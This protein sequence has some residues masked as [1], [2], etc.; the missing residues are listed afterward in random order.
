MVDSACSHPL[1]E[2]CCKRRKRIAGLMSGTSLDGLDV[3][4]LDIEGNGLLTCWKLLAFDIYKYPD[5]IKTK[6]H[7][8]C[9]SSIWNADDLCR[10]NVWL[11]KFFANAVIDLCKQSGIS[12][13]QI[14]VIGS[15]GQTIRHLPKEVNFS[16]LPIAG[17][18][19]VG[20]P[21][22]IAKLTG[23]P[24]V[25]DFRPADMALGGQGAP[26]VPIVDYML[27]RSDKFNRGILNIGGISNITIIDA[28]A[29]QA[30]VFAFDIGPGNMIIDRL[31]QM[32]FDKPMDEEARIASSGSIHHEFLL[33]LLQFDYL[34]IPP[35]KSTGR[36][37]F[38]DEFI[39][40]VLSQ[41]RQLNLGDRDILATVT[42]FVS[43]CVRDALQKFVAPGLALDEI[44]V[45]GGGAYNPLIMSHLAASLRPVK[46]FRSDDAGIP[47]DAK[48][49][50]CFAILANETLAGHPGN[51]PGVTGAQK[52]TILGKICL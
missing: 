4:I 16:A 31:A 25:A 46:V 12:P 49:A 9:T 20:E 11:G 40:T 43:A 28:R 21:S 6:L 41:A 27:F 8:I 33:Q 35:P 18:L 13:K 38:G 17:T 2:L 47:A 52:P 42:A 1:L 24:T 15:H 45:G 26:L 37:M 39:Q 34:S 48:E 3:A 22:V 5:E 50:I 10:I 14:D 19:Q 36:E 51:L 32:L 7:S 29:T 30:D 23:I 44:F